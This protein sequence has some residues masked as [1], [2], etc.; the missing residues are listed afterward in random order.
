MRY[1][2]G[3]MVRIK[4][5]DWYNRYTN[6]TEVDCGAYPFT[7][8]MK[9]F[10]GQERIIANVCQECY[11]LLGI[12]DKFV[13]TDE[14]IE[15]LVERNG[16][17]YPYK[18][19]DR[20]VLKGNNRSATI[21][22]LKYN[23]WGNL[24]YYIKID[25]DKDISIDY[26]TDLLLPY[27]NMIEALVEEETK[28]EPKFKV[29]DRV[30]TDTNMKG[31]IIEV[32]EEGWYRVEFEPYNGI[33]QPNGVVPEESMTLVEEEIKSEDGLL[34]EYEE[35]TDRAF[36]GGYEKC[37]SDIELNGFQL[38]KGYIFKDENGNVINATKIVLEKKKKEY[39]KTYEECCEIVKVGKKHT[40]EGEI[41]RI[42]NYKIALLESFQKLLICRD[43]Y[44]KIAGEEM[45]LG[46]PWEPDYD[47]GVNKFGIIYMNGV[48]QESNPTTNWERHLNKNL[49]F[50][51]AEMRDA[52]K[53][54]FGPYIEICK[55]LL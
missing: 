49:D 13:W 35:L 46:K 36:K 19:G 27:D 24:S 15:G 14:M 40:L 39:P 29:G 3:D 44:W 9:E 25:N 32:V 10:C 7:S 28:P 4:S 54:N 41:I 51:T 12:D 30:I 43:A 22:D 1:N 23:S 11:V 52:F 53:E 48:V 45:G 26:P 34:D 38:P 8:D 20:V 21:T 50:P 33:P 6:G 47:S 16:K 55:E 5:L 18:I 31:K 42:N 2:V 37:K 17:T